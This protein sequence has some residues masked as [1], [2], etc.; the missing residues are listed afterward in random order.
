MRYI[1]LLLLLCALL[2]GTSANAQRK[3][4]DAMAFGCK[5]HVKSKTSKQLGAS[6]STTTW[7]FNAQ[8][9]LISV[10]GK[11]IKPEYIERDS[12]NRLTYLSIIDT[13]WEYEN[14]FVSAEISGPSGKIFGWTWDASK[15]QKIS[16]FVSDLEGNL[17][18]TTTIQVVQT[19]SHGNATKAFITIDQQP[20]IKQTAID[21]YEYW[22]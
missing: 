4:Y 17:M 11:E 10:N 19:D 6:N 8:G 15:K 21:S 18:A 22:Q 3:Y 12:N 16:G 1:N 9:A 2:V 5:G 7:R 20:S 14:G 13:A